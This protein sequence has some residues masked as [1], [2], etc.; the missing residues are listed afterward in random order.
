MD[1]AHPPAASRVERNVEVLQ[2]QRMQMVSFA[3]E[4]RQTMVAMRTPAAVIDTRIGM[5]INDNNN[6]NSR[7][8]PPL[9]S[10]LF[11]Q[12]ENDSQQAFSPQQALV[13][14]EPEASL[15]LGRA[16]GCGQDDEGGR[17]WWHTHIG[18]FRPA[19]AKGP[20][21]CRLQPLKH[22][23]QQQKSLSDGRFVQSSVSNDRF[24]DGSVKDDAVY[25]PGDTLVEEKKKVKKKKK[26]KKKK[27]IRK[28]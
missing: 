7:R 17:W 18:A 27:K 8:A 11:E 9:L 5:P 25:R 1:P 19:Q 16:R 21:S 4:T 24:S 3:E 26:K 12:L 20:I 23:G 28:N 13:T 14:P 15:C 6:N 22:T 2:Q 10:S